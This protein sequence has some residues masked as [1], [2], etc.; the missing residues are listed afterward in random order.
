MLLKAINF[1]T[2]AISPFVLIFSK[3]NWQGWEDT[4]HQTT[5]VKFIMNIKYYTTTK[6]YFYYQINFKND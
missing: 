4:G 2:S 1:H 3:Y 6:N 5:N